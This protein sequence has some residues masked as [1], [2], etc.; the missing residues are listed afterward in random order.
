MKKCIAAFVA[1]AAITGPAGS[2]AQEYPVKPIRIILPFAPGAGTDLVARL[3]AQRFTAAWGQPALVDNRAGAGGNIGAELVVRSPPDGHTLLMST[4]SLTVNVTLYPKLPFDVRRD[5]MPITQVGSVPIVVTVH[6][7]VPAKNLKE[8]LALAKTRKEGLNF[9][10]NGTGT[11]SHLAGEWLMQASG[12]KLTH[13]PFKGA[14]AAMTSM[15][16]GE[17]DIGFPGTTSARPLIAANK[18][19]GIAVTTLRRASVLPDLPTVA[20]VFSGFD[21]DNWF[22]LWAPAGTSPAIINKVQEEV[23]KSLPHPDVKAY[24]TR[25]G[26]EPIGSTPAEFAAH[27]HHEIEKYARVIKLSGAKPDA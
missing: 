2:Y 21:V 18:L 19:R 4:A 20:T 12:L 14:S 7:S 25:E 26:V 1:V 9:G 22:A 27:I 15:L 5:L 24:M 8:L 6:P 23:V 13:I 3:L 17:F 11:T 10:S 16:G